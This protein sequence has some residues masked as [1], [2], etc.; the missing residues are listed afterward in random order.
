MLWCST[1]IVCITL[2][3]MAEVSQAVSGA[4]PTVCNLE[5]T[6]DSYFGPRSKVIRFP[7]KR[8]FTIIGLNHGNRDLQGGSADQLQHARTS[9]DIARILAADP[10]ALSDATEAVRFLT[11]ASRSVGFVAAEA[12][13]QTVSTNLKSYAAVQSKIQKLAGAESAMK[14]AFGADFY[15]KLNGGITKLVGVEDAELG[16]AYL[17]VLPV[18]Q[19]E[20]AKLARAK[21]DPDIAAR[22]NDFVGTLISRYVSLNERDDLLKD[23]R[24]KFTAQ[25]FAKLEPFLKARFDVMRAMRARDR[26]DVTQLLAQK[27]S[28]IFLI[29]SSHLD[30]VAMLLREAC[31]TSVK[32]TPK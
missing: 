25:D 12:S 17:K 9:A 3:L 14:L 32:P 1:M 11:L 31:V 2:G 8:V 13:P 15:L 30:S 5:A 21:F 7:D 16:A 24:A 29:G 4:D 19:K 20:T 27:Q 26:H 23:A 10:P 18:L 28:G 22:M 6:S